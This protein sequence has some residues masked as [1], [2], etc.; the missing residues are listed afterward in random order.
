MAESEN[1]TEINQTDMTTEVRPPSTLF[2]RILASIGLFSLGFGAFNLISI[3][4]IALRNSSLF[5]LYSFILSVLLVAGG[6]ILFI[7]MLFLNH[8]NVNSTID[9][10]FASEINTIEES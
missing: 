1:E 8:I 5:N 10:N 6:I 4:I 7:G 3:I 9:H 2:I